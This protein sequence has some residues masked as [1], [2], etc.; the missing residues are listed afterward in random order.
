MPGTI[1]GTD[2]IFSYLAGT[3]EEAKRIP[4]PVTSLGK[5]RKAN[6]GAVHDLMAG[7]WSGRTDKRQI[8]FLINSGTQGLQ[9]AA[10]GGKAYELAKQKGLGYELPTEWFLQNIRD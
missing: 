6:S 7:R 10:V 5:V 2:G 9:F 1:T 8:T 4:V 3:S